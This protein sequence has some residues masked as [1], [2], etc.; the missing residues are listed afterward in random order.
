[1][2]VAVLVMVASVPAFGANG[3]GAQTAVTPRQTAPVTMVLPASHAFANAG[4]HLVALSPDGARVVYVAN[5]RLYQRPVYEPEAVPI[6]AAGTDGARNP[7]YSPDGRWIGFWQDRQLKKIATT[8]G[9]P[10]VLCA[11]QNP[12]GASWAIDN[13]IFYGQGA[14][15]V[16]RVSGNGGTPEQV[17]KLDAG[18]LAHGPQL[19]PG[20]GSL[21]FTLAG[22]P[23]WDT[24]QIVVQ[25]IEHGTRRVVLDR[26]ADARYVS[27]GHIVFASGGALLAV[28][29]DGATLS[30]TGRPDRLVEDVAQ[31][32]GEAYSPSI[33]PDGTA[34]VFQVIRKGE[35]L[36]AVRPIDRC[37]GL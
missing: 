32:P 5:N 13:T 18:Q 27:T 10:V 30:V 34:L 35:P 37:A 23:D 3:R 36:L 25:S 24:A 11:A 26:A 2:R 16:W 7:F 33:S 20:G 31:A 15:G 9:L 6:P 22:S 17:V 29:F 28:P 8:G 12:Q 1:M 14:N 19:L 4:R 21:L